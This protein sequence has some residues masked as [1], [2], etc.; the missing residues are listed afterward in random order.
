MRGLKSVIAV[1]IK[2][3]LGCV[4][5]ILALLILMNACMVGPKY[6]KPV[7]E[8]PP[9]YKEQP[10]GPSTGEWK[11]AQPSDQQSKGKW[12]EIYSDSQLNALEER[13]SVSNQ[14]LKVSEAL[15]RQ[16]RAVVR[17]NRSGY[18]PT[19]SGTVSITAS[20]PSANR[21]LTTAASSPTFGDYLLSADM[22]Y[23]L[24]VWGRIHRLVEGSVANAQA[25]DADLET[26]RLSIQSEL[27]TDYFQLRAFDSERQ[28]LDST[29]T[30]YTK[31]L[32]LTT[33][34]YKGGVA[35]KVEV[36]QAETQLE[37]TRAE[38]IDVGVQR[39]QLEH[40]IAL[41]VGA[42]ASTFSIP[43]QPLTVSPPK[44]PAGLPS[45]LLERRPDIAAAE[46]RVAAANAQIGIAKAA[47][48][49]VLSIAASV[50]FETTQISN[51][52]SWPSHLW[53]VGPALAQTLF[54]AGRRRAVSD[55][56]QAAYDATV[57]TY[58]QSVLTAF[59]E[60]EDNLAALRILGE[61]AGVQDSAVKASE[62]SLELSMNRYKGGVVS[63]LEVTTAQSAALTN[64]RTAVDILGREM[65]ASVLLV[66][67][68]GGGWDASSLPST[69]EIESS[70]PKASTNAIAAAERKID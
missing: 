66:K 51:W 25:S 11:Q 62:R 65:V 15:F 45:E 54:D 60:V 22:S 21:S 19:V 67:A 13:V 28:L 5:G 12:W 16:A 7:A 49:P 14:N 69:Q 57:G 39:A 70:V 42:P 46:R 53:A 18:Y 59:Q 3:Q 41:L 43:P 35:S 1:C 58:R 33:N 10:P 17:A 55:Q 56:A 50:G 4:A 32:E 9:A 6:T 37:T 20:H 68:L 31:A 24:D 23:E 63:Y 38:A 8:V 47:Y 61:E 34:R 52:F 29:V 30:A 27:A 44:I 2:H 40:A 36:A 48:Y 26:I 64:E